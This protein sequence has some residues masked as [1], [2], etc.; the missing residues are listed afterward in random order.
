[1]PAPATKSFALSMACWACLAAAASVPDA[2]VFPESSFC[3]VMS[4]SAGFPRAFETPSDATRTLFLSSAAPVN[5]PYFAT[6]GKAGQRAS[7]APAPRAYEANASGAARIEPLL[8]P[9]DPAITSAGEAEAAG[10]SLSSRLP[11]C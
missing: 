10:A 11:R 4:L 7:S 6:L 1:M 3:F 8:A 9:H 5:L 2:V